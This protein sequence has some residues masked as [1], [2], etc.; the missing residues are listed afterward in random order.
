ML[1]SSQIRPQQGEI[2]IADCF[3]HV[4]SEIKKKRPVLILSNEVMHTTRLR[5][6]VPLR[7]ARPEH[8]NLS[9]LVPVPPSII[10]NLHTPSSADCIQVKSFDILRFHHY[11][12]KVHHV[13]LQ[14]IQIMLEMVTKLLDKTPDT[15]IP[16]P[17]C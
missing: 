11:V 16:A 10:T 7:S 6:I 1:S 17:N 9:F 3:P 15:Y 5:I 12:G 8:R 4:G 2:W 13:V 14:E